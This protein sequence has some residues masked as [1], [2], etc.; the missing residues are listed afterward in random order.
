MRAMVF[1]GL[2]SHS[3]RRKVTCFGDGQLRGGEEALHDVLVHAG[4]RAED[5]G[6][7][8]GDSGEF[9]ETLD[10]AVFAEGSV[11]NR[12]D[13]VEAER[14]SRRRGVKVEGPGVGLEGDE[15]AGPA[16]RGDGRHDDRFA[17]REDGGGCGGLGIAGAQG[18]GRSGGLSGEQTRSIRRGDPAAFLGD[19]DGDDRRTFSDRWP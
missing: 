19:A 3:E 1:F 13:D 2:A 7:D 18:A 11:K 4:G 15:G 8:V 12:E 14:R 9:E 5:T 17:A 6:A 10:G 16:L